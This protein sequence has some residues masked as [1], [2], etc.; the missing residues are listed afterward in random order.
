M[1]R[2]R[3]FTL[4]EMLAALAVLA[5]CATVL[6]GAF[7]ES[8]RALQQ[9]ARSDRLNLAA[10]SL[11]D[12]LGEGPLASGRRQGQWQGVA[13]V[14]DVSQVPSVAGAARL[15]RLQL[16]LKADGRQAQFSTLWVRGS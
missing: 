12:E 16:T 1:N 15:F 7:G 11:M 3:G 2:Q 6:L 5:L 14:C 10:R 13:W 8:A 9:S 4:L